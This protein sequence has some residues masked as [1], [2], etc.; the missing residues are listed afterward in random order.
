MYAATIHSVATKQPLKRENAPF[1]IQ[2]KYVVS[3]NSKAHMTMGSYRA[4][5]MITLIFMEEPGII[6][7]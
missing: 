1:T 7:Q 3:F 2:G 4:Q 6:K 5:F